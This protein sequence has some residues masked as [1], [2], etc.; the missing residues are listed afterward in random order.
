MAAQASTG[1]NT[2]SSYAASCEVF[3]IAAAPFYNCAT[4]EIGLIAVMEQVKFRVDQPAKLDNLARGVIQSGTAIDRHQ[5][6]V[7]V[8]H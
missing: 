8:D 5:D 2:P 1:S 6:L 4:S 7:V 3:S